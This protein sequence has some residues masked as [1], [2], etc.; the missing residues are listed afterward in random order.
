M[1]DKIHGEP[2]KLDSRTGE[3]QMEGVL[4]TRVTLQ[5]DLDL[6]R[7]GGPLIEDV[8]PPARIIDRA[9]AVLTMGPKAL[10]APPKNP[11]PNDQFGK[12]APPSGGSADDGK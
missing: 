8:M 11:Q 9:V 4:R 2:L 5:F 3:P 10:S 1:A 12:L 6:R 7:F